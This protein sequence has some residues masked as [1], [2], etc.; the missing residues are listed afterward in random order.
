MPNTNPFEEGR[1]EQSFQNGTNTLIENFLT[2]NFKV[3]EKH[4]FTFL[5]GYSYQNNQDRWRIWSIDNFADNGIEPRYNPGLGQR[6]NM[7][8]NKPAGWAYINELQSYFGR[9]NYDYN[10]KYLITATLRS[11]V[12]PNSVRIIN[13]VYSHHLRQDGD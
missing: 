5:A 9:I 3:A 11:D 6:L 7:V 10:N 13:M 1:L 4:K 12:L 2:Y 8:D